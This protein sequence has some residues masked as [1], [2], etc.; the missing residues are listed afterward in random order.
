MSEFQT[1]T[2]RDPPGLPGNSAPVGGEEWLCIYC[3]CNSCVCQSWK[4]VAYSD[5]LP[6]WP[7]ALVTHDPYDPYENVIHQTHWPMTQRPVSTSGVWVSIAKQKTFAQVFYCLLNMRQHYRVLLRCRRCSGAAV[8]QR[9]I[10]ILLWLTVGL[11]LNI[12]VCVSCRT[13]SR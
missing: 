1:D 3:T 7:I 11:W 4:W 6:K 10:V 8:D 13:T 9:L 2:V 5:P 12:W